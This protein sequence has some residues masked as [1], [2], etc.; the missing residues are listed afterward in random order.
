[1]N[2]RALQ[3][4]SAPEPTT[5]D[6]WPVDV[7]TA[8]R[9]VTPLGGR[10]RAR[11]W[12]PLLLFVAV[13][14]VLW[15]VVGVSAAHLSRTEL[16]LRP[17]H[18]PGG[19]VVEGWTRWDGHWYRTIVREGYVYYPGVQ[20]S[21]AFFP[22]YPLV[23]AA[24]ASV[25]PSI[26]VSGVVV[27]VASGAVAAVAFHRWC[28]QWLSPAA[29]TTALAVL[30]LYPYAWYLYGAVYADAL[31]LAAMLVAFVALERDRVW[32]A[33]LAG[34][35]ASGAR[36]VGLVVAVGLVLRLIERRN[37]EAGRVR[38]DA[39]LTVGLAARFSPRGLRRADLPVFVAFGGFTAWCAYLWVRFGDPV[40][41]ATVQRA[42][43]WDQGEG[44]ATWSKQFLIEELVTKPHVP[45]VWG[46]V[47]QGVLALGML[48]LVGRIARR[49]GWAYAVFTLGVV[50]LPVIGT[51]DFAGTGR[52]LL[53][54]FPCAAVAGEW[55][56]GHPRLRF[57]ALAASGVVLV[58]LASAFAR[59]HY[60]A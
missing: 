58:L 60:L 25:V 47:A 10:A 2:E 37:V 34:A 14:A 15:L 29:A 33:G 43:G 42:P 19:F 9:G 24:L 31:C 23:V 36:P 4:R 20:S 48:A 49:F 45:F 3:V 22:A 53:A 50:L 6:A 7:G 59:G 44:W 13:G 51:K 54:A 18:V 12:V 30:L 5:P 39:P 27:T 46:K 17:E 21:V 16:Y 40:A 8:G 41:F 57:G 32:L 56:S 38:D 11:R 52:Y 1:M 26:W 28:S 55:L 35:V